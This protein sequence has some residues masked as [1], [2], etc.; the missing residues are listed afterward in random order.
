MLVL[1]WNMLLCAGL[2]LWVRLSVM[3]LSD[4]VPR[5]TV[6]VVCDCLLLGI[7]SS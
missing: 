3:S 7:C 5:I 2:D 4:P 1:L 6:M